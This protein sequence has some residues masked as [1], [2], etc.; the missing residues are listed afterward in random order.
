MLAINTLP[1]RWVGVVEAGM[2]SRLH[3][4]VFGFWSD[5]YQNENS[6]RIPKVLAEF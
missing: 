3:V 5:A 2:A 4:L 6:A 1:L